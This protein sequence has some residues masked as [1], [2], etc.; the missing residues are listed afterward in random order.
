MAGPPPRGRSSAARGHEPVFSRRGRADGPDDVIQ[1]RTERGQAVVVDR[2]DHDLRVILQA[3]IGAVGATTWERIN[4]RL[5]ETQGVSVRAMRN[6]LTKLRQSAVPAS[7]TAAGRDS[8]FWPQEPPRNTRI[9]Q[10]PDNHALPSDGA[11]A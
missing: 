1:R 7:R 2:D 10:S 3:T 4:R 5:L 11:L 9:A 8:G 6:P